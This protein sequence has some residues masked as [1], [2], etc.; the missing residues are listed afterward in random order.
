MTLRVAV[1]LDPAFLFEN[2][3]EVWAPQ[4]LDEAVS[5]LRRAD[6]ARRAG[7]WIAGALSYEFG[8]QLQG[9]NAR[10]SRP[11]FLLGA[12]DA[13]RRR[14][15]PQRRGRFALSAPLRRISA[16]QYAAAIA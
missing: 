5:A 16:P 14:A 7:Y 4:T 2:P 11:L 8:A 6:D 10:T 9:V 13:C 12:Y 3:R 15:L 1:G